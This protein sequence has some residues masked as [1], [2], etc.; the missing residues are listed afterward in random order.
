[1]LGG[2]I[3]HV[4]ESLLPRTELLKRLLRSVADPRAVLKRFTL[5]ACSNQLQITV[6][7]L[8]VSSRTTTTLIEARSVGCR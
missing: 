8:S 6:S 1:M 5:S 2:L 7:C 3:I 4:V